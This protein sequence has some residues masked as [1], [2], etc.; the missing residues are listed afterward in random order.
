MNARETVGATSEQDRS[1]P[2]LLRDRSRTRYRTPRARVF[3]GQTCE[4]VSAMNDEQDSERPYVVL[5]CS[6]IR[7]AGHAGGRSHH[8]RSPSDSEKPLRL[9]YEEMTASRAVGP[10]AETLAPIGTPCTL[11]GCSLD[12]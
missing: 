8:A 12:A 2:R 11:E 4:T 1:T 5:V 6:R 7:P 9:E 3:A 10:Y